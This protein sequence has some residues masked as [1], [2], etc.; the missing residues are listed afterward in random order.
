M[1]AATLGRRLPVAS[2][3]PTFTRCPRSSLI[4]SRA[5]AALWGGGVYFTSDFGVTWD[6]LDT[7]TRSASSVMIGGP[8]GETLYLADRQSPVVYRNTIPAD[9]LWGDWDVAF[10]A[11]DEYYRVLNAV[12]SGGASDVLYVSLFGGR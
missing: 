4:P 8:S 2:T 7:P 10:D 6:E 9:G 12:A 11:G 5:V 1:T 3:S